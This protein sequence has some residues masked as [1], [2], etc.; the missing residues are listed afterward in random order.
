MR[1]LRE[2]WTIPSI[3]G[4][5]K[6]LCGMCGSLLHYAARSSLAAR[7]PSVW[8]DTLDAL[9]LQTDTDCAINF[10]LASHDERQC[11]CL[12][13]FMNAESPV[14][15]QRFFCVFAKIKKSTVRSLQYTIFRE[16]FLSVPFSTFLAIKVTRII[17]I[18][19]RRFFVSHNN[20]IGFHER[21]LSFGN[22][23]F[24]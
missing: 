23:A 20:L 24:S 16:N 4:I 11:L 12:S 7:C 13:W 1:E 14:G 18:K 19:L 5:K 2:T 10:S 21:K 9:P 8:E 17:K 15:Y 3:F 6:E 22:A